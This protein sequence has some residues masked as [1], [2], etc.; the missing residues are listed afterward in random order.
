MFFD[1]TTGRV[2]T[3]KFRDQC[4]RDEFASFRSDVVE[5]QP[6][7]VVLGNLWDS[8]LDRAYGTV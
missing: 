1:R 6:N 5:H 7:D 8:V 3:Q 4:V 2:A